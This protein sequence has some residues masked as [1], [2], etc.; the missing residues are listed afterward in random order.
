MRGAATGD[1]GH[2]I[3]IDDEQKDEDDEDNEDGEDDKQSEAP[4]LS[5]STTIFESLQDC[6]DRSHSSDG[7]GDGDGDGGDGDGDGGDGSGGGGG[8]SC[9]SGSSVGLEDNTARAAAAVA[10][11]T[12][13]TAT[14]TAAASGRREHNA[15]SATVCDTV[16]VPGDSQYKRREESGNDDSS[17]RAKASP[18]VT[19][20]ATAS[21]GPAHA[22]GSRPSL[23]G[24]TRATAK[25][26][27]ARPR[28]QAGQGVNAQFRPVRPSAS[29]DS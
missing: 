9:N 8:G 19:R 27:G 12:A 24:R 5:T 2:T 17:N 26:L 14:T 3:T 20:P 6:L 21:G 28:R 13:A 18:Q 23:R 1:A 11:S 16:E 22:N 4:L 10:N 15:R 25:A 29:K 7:D